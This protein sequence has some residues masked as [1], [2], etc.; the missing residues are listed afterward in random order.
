MI[1]RIFFAAYAFCLLAGAALATVSEPFG[2]RPATF[3]TASVRVVQLPD[4]VVVGK[5]SALPSTLARTE[6]GETGETASQRAQ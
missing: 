1:D 4:V 3:T 5:R 2:M 6:A